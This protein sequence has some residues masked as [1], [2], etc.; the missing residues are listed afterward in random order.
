MATLDLHVALREHG[1]SAHARKAC[2]PERACVVGSRRHRR[3]NSRPNPRNPIIGNQ[4]TGN[5]GP[6]VH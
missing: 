2:H 5:G 6:V 3:I 4:C 1:R